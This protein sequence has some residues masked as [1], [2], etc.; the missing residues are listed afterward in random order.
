M[1]GYSENEIKEKLEKI[2]FALDDCGAWLSADR[3]KD[4]NRKTQIAMIISG[5]TAVVDLESGAVVF[6]LDLSKIEKMTL[7][8]EISG[9]RI[10]C[11]T[12]GAD[13]IAA[14]M[15]Y[16]CKDDAYKFVDVFEKIKCGQSFEKAKPDDCICPKCGMRYPDKGRKFCPNCSDNG[17]VIG[18]MSV[19]FKK[20]IPQMVITFLLLALQ[21]VISV[22]APYISSGFYYDEVL[23]A[24][25][26]FYGQLLFVLTLV[27]ALRLLRIGVETFSS[28]VSS[29]I[30]AKLAFDMK[31]TVFD[32]IER[33]SVSYFSTRST[34]GLM[35]QVNNDSERIYWFFTD[36]VPNLVINAV[37]FVCVF[38][39]MLTINPLLT[40]LS[41]IL[42]PLS[43]YL[44]GK[45]YNHNR[46]L[47]AKQYSKER[48]MNGMLSDLLTGIRVVKTF[49]TEKREAARFDSANSGLARASRRT[50]LFSS[51]A[52]PLLNVLVYIGVV[53]VWAVGGRMVITESFGMTYGLLLTFIAY[54]SMIYSPMYMLVDMAQNAS[55][56][57]NAMSRLL[58]IMDAKPEV[59][60]SENPVKLADFKGKVE[61]RNVK[62]SYVKNR[63]VLDN[64]TFDIEA[65]GNVGIVGHTGAGKST[66]ANLLIRLYDVDD[67]E[68]LIDG[69]NIK[70]L[71]FEDLHKNI[72][73]VSQETYLFSGT[74]YDNIRYSCSSASKQEVIA[75]AK[76]AGAHDFI[77]KLPDGYETK[78]GQGYKE[79]SGG[80]RQRISIARA[81][82][83]N[84]KI[85]ILDE[86]TAAMDTK[87]E[88][89]IQ[90]TLDKLSEGRTTITIAHRLSTLK[91]AD[92]LFVIKD[93]TVCE[94]G[95]P[96]ELI[97]KKGVYWR[98]YT[99]QLEALRDA[100]IAE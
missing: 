4:G 64:I 45:A 80:E 13:L 77:S 26:S 22:V 43:V 53:V 81:I 41:L 67:G 58:E 82:L 54:I 70:N 24:D 72:A 87:T 8:E 74:I 69:V 57:M 86:A 16:A 56:S 18:R 73:I 60:E 59:G 32:S 44:I 15:S 38:I 96:A 42:L 99:L 19:F 23:S 29:K 21:S 3:D 49:A 85:L 61:F 20:Y 35:N 40:F 50:S 100:G 95:R 90:K 27:I 83:R 37:Q 47:H 62:F 11:R 34:G 89:M 36:G 98:L 1:S 55:E 17:K 84:P 39:I 88:Q 76:A 7:E 28:I 46:M 2:G 71:S 31:K 63:T 51:T 25:G 68:I 94:S 75:A 48:S 92:K 93:K 33:L 12:A 97:A 91:K 79:L 6:R 14:S 9:C 78:V 5:Q 30:S 10:V 65:G 52:Y 66:I